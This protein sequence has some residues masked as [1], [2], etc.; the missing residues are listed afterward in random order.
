MTGV[1]LDRPPAR[2]A[3]PELLVLAQWEEFTGWLFTATARWPKY[4]R[5]TLTQRIEN[6]ALDVTEMLVVARYEPKMRAAT[7]KQVN[8]VLERMRFLFRIALAKQVLPIKTF[9]CAMRHVDETGRM[10]HG[11]RQAQ[12]L[13]A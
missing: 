3:G 7:L 10:I 11:W 2:Q 1:P 6:H 12:E 13:S 5:F 4:A 9:E 8:L